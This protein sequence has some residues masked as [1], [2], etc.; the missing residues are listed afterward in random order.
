MDTPGGASWPPRSVIRHPTRPR[1]TEGSG[2]LP[3]RR[4][5]A[6]S[7]VVHVGTV[8]G[9]NCD[10]SGFLCGRAG[11]CCSLRVRCDTAIASRHH[12]NGHGNK[13]LDL[14]AERTIGKCRAAQGCKSLINLRDHSA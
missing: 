9:C 12:S 6:V 2:R 8:H 1:A 11:T 14:L 3:V 5:G 10:L 13:V 4:S 7:L